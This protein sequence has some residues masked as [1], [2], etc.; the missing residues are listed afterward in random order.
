[1]RPNRHNGSDATVYDPSKMETEAQI[2]LNPWLCPDALT[3]TH[4]DWLT[5]SI[6]KT[7]FDLFRFPESI[8]NSGSIV[9]YRGTIP[10]PS[11]TLY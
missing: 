7:K 6:P 10:L 8:K 5:T 3:P 1:M 2:F 9:V 11:L 4:T